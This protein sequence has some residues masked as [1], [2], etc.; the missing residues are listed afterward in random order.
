[1][2]INTTQLTFFKIPIIE[3]SGRD[4]LQIYKFYIY[5]F[6]SVFIYLNAYSGKIQTMILVFVFKT[7]CVEI[8]YSIL[9][10]GVH[11]APGHLD[12]LSQMD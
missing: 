2:T 7:L 8:V 5:K 6:Y 9:V 10:Q 1:M 3:Q 12:V 11:P 4:F